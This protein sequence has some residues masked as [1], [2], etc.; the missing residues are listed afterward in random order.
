M[1]AHWTIWCESTVFNLVFLL[2]DFDLKIFKLPVLPLL[3]N[4]EEQGNAF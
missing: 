1:Y 3:V 4:P 2:L